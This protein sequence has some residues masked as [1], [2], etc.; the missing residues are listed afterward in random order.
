MDRAEGQNIRNLHLQCICTEGVVRD[1]QTTTILERCWRGLSFL[2]AFSQKPNRKCNL[3][4]RA[5]CFETS[6][7][8]RIWA[9]NAHEFLSSSKQSWSWDEPIFRRT[10]PTAE[11][12]CERKVQ[13]C[14]LQ[15]A[16]FYIVVRKFLC[17]Q[18]QIIYIKW[19]VCTHTDI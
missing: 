14:V 13:C 9:V 6:K 3:Y 8:T 7:K 5:I 15:W 10:L 16:V 2:K 4:F 11:S 19:T 17:R 12:S 18:M 1:R